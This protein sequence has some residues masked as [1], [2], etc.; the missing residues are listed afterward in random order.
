[1]TSAA[2]S[3]NSA[4][5]GRIAYGFAR[6]FQV[7]CLEATPE[8]WRVAFSDKTPEHALT[9]AQRV[10]PAPIDWVYCDDAALLEKT[11]NQ[12]YSNQETN[13]AA[14][15][16]EGQRVFLLGPVGGAQQLHAQHA[17]VEIDGSLQV[18]DAQHGV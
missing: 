12:A 11:I 17:G 2:L 10:A 15:A 18:T 4:T 1:M 14:V 8:R 16:D 5:V 3:F 9:E 6:Q 13:A 7:L